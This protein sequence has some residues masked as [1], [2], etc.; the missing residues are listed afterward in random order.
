MYDRLKNRSSIRKGI[1]SIEGSDTGF[2]K[3]E[4][5]ILFAKDLLDMSQ[6]K[7]CPFLLNII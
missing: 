3:I 1:Q 5:L 7:I 6:P 4:D 2:I